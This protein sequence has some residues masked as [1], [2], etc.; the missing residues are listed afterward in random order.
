ML[1]F[2]NDYMLLVVVGIC[3]CIGYMLKNA[4]PKFPNNMIPA[5]MGILGVVIA[6]WAKG[7]ITPDVLLTGLISGLASTGLHQ[8]LTKFINKEQQ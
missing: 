6:I 5:S 3:L 1:D 4:F 8:T 2:L 7:T